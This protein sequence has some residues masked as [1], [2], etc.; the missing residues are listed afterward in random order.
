M[1]VSEYNLE[2]AT[3]IPPQIS[4]V[5]S[6]ADGPGKYYL[7][8]VNPNNPKILEVME[9]A[10][11]ENI[12]NL[13]FFYYIHNNLNTCFK[14]KY[15]TSDNKAMC[16]AAKSLVDNLQD[17]VAETFPVQTLSE[18][19]SSPTAQLLVL[20]SAT[21]SGKSTVTPSFF[22]KWNR[23][24][25]TNKKR[26]IC[27]QPRRFNVM[28]ITASLGIF[29]G[30]SVLS[31][32]KIIPDPK[33]F[34]YVVGGMSVGSQDA[35][36]TII[37]EGSL[38]R[39]FDPDKPNWD[40]IVI[41]EVHERNIDTDILLYKIRKHYELH[42]DSTL[43]VIIMSAT[44][45]PDQFLNYFNNVTY[46]S[47]LYIRGD[48]KNVKNKFLKAP[49]P[50]YC[51]SAAQ[52]IAK[53]HLKKP[54]NNI[55]DD[56]IVFCYSEADFISIKAK[57]DTM[58]S[59]IDI[60]SQP[61]RFSQ[62]AT[63]TAAV[64]R[65]TKSNPNK[66]YEIPLSA[67]PQSPTRRIIFATNYAETGV[68]INGL[69]YVVDTCFEQFNSFDPLNGVNNLYKVPCSQN[70]LCQR[71]GRVGRKQDGEYYPML[72]EKSLDT[73]PIMALPKILTSDSFPEAMLEWN[74]LGRG[75]L[76]QKF[77]Y[78]QTFY[79]KGLCTHLGITRQIATKLYDLQGS[80][81]QRLAIFF[82]SRDRS[83]Q[84]ALKIA[85]ASIK[86][87][88]KDIPRII[89]NS[90]MDRL[91]VKSDF[92]LMYEIFRFYS[93]YGPKYLPPIYKDYVKLT[94]EDLKKQNISLI[95][96]PFLTEQQQLFMK[97]CIIRAYPHNTATLAEDGF[98]YRCDNRG[99]ILLNLSGKSIYLE[100]KIGIKEKL[101]NPRTSFR[102]RSLKK[103]HSHY[104]QKVCFD[105]IGTN[106]EGLSYTANYITVLSD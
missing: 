65:V 41:D 78:E 5:A 89:R 32:N 24:Q 98:H 53:I 35:D 1:A 80:L 106:P 90:F 91:I 93:I 68:T 67:L 103:S 102:D 42:N 64:M 8:P 60:D 74:Q 14:E 61:M 72:T 101:L 15:Y 26:L 62:L 69:G 97:D 55:K 31:E 3:Y 36:V 27:T 11:K 37:T 105:N 38:Q 6:V 39:M 50:D 13:P 104:P 46:K 34:R 29:T 59:T 52:R 12:N 47:K 85:F 100:P 71:R 10:Y 44:I 57:L 63:K 28:E 48:S 49:T 18:F 22:K 88:P 51:L 66:K 9:K 86:N 16:F 20:Q 21:G 70:S 33:H 92:L 95:G 99:N 43:K 96:L 84:T 2:V 76:L 4:D 25:T 82:A 81:E 94:I 58:I 75:E 19:F 40:I 56:I 7:Q 87:S 79:Y 30:Y 17:Y 73:L 54:I 45:D 23:D 83:V 77:S